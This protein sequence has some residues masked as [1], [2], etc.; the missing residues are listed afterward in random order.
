[1]SSAPEFQ[2]TSEKLLADYLDQHGYAWEYEPPISG[3]DK[4]PDFRIRRET[5]ECLCDVKER[6]PKPLPPGARNFDPIKGIRKLIKSGREKFREFDC[7]LCSL[8]VYNNGDL[9]TLLLPDYI[10]GA[11]LGNP[12][13]EFDFDASS[14]TLDTQTGRNVFLSRGGQM[15]RHYAPLEAHDSATNIGAIVILETYRV[16]NPAFDRAFREQSEEREKRLGRSL[17]EREECILNVSLLESIPAPLTEVP[18]LVVCTN[19]F[20]HHPIPENVFN[21]PYDERWSIQENHLDRVF[22]GRELRDSD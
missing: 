18:R 6:S 15:I 21:G 5:V 16:P 1:M 14:G 7:D 22:V 20:A 9:D 12:G 19:P 11:V 10:Y 13:I 4:V 3:K 8:V 2:T 17:T